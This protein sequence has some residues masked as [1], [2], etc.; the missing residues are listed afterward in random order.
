M[1]DTLTP[2]Q[3]AKLN[4]YREQWL[5][6]GLC[7]DPADRPRAEEHI[8]ALY[9][10]ISLPQPITCWV[11]GPLQAN[12]FINLLNLTEDLWGKVF[13]DVLKPAG[14]GKLRKKA[15]SLLGDNDPLWLEFNTLLSA[16]LVENVRIGLGDK[17]VTINPAL[18]TNLTS[19]LRL[20][21]TPLLGEADYQSLA[22][23]FRVVAMKAL[24]GPWRYC[25]G[26]FWGN[27]DSNW[28]AYHLF[29][30]DVIKAD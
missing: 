11:D 4:E 6:V 29:A 15:V 27:W 12:V 20:T 13:E 22:E 1:A 2:A 14:M 8:T 9:R 19:F 17:Y 18:T 21:L 5:K 3:E 26:L 7:A 28:C 25:D 24:V 23:T 16:A 30:R 10:S